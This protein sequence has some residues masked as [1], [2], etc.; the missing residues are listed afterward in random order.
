MTTSDVLAD[1]LRIL[2]VVADLG[3]GLDLPDRQRYRRCFGDSVAVYNPA[4]QGAAA[5]HTYTGDEWADRVGATQ[6]RLTTVHS[7]TCASTEID[8]VTAETV[9]MQQALFA[10][11][12]G[13][14]RVA[15]PLRLT[16][17]KAAGTW[18]ID[19]LRFDVTWRAG[20][21]DVYTRARKA[22]R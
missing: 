21:P 5:W 4:F 7:L 3:L 22:A 16:L 14:Y 9:L 15:G 13:S 17:N 8:G 11:A 12:G 6:E 19:R 18:R 1:K 10:D 20:D 2:D